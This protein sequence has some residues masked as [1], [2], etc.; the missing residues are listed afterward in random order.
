ME[1]VG[2]G[3]IIAAMKMFD[4]PRENCEEF[5]EVYK[6]VVSHYLVSMFYYHSIGCITS[7]LLH[8]KTTRNSVLLHFMSFHLL[9]SKNNFQ[10]MAIELSNG[11][12][13]ALEIAA[14]NPAANVHSDFR[15]FCGPSDPVHYLIKIFHFKLTLFLI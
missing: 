5:Y 12:F 8:A 15:Q 6:G 11:P 7:Y 9:I 4:L 1:I 3:F 13:V 2:S 10:Q 14:E